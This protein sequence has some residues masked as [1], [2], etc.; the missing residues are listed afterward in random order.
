MRSKFLWIYLGYLRAHPF[1]PHSWRTCNPNVILFWLNFNKNDKNKRNIVSCSPAIVDFVHQSWLSDG[2]MTF[3]IL[4]STAEWV[5][6]RWWRGQ[7]SAFSS[8]RIISPGSAFLC[9]QPMLVASLWLRHRHKCKR[10]KR[11][12]RCAEKMTVEEK[13]RQIERQ[14][15]IYHLFPS[16][17]ERLDKKT[18]SCHSIWSGLYPPATHE[19]GSMTAGLH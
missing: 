6:G 10:A 17:S 16:S 7:L 11:A 15:P 5:G 14:L 2:K 4:V 12:R 3:S 18:Q 8:R 1:F 19:L 13:K 9:C